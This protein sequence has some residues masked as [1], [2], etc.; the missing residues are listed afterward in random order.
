MTSD[1]SPPAVRGRGHQSVVMAT[2]RASVDLWVAEVFA[3]ELGLVSELL[4]D[5][6]G[7]RSEVRSPVCSS[8]PTP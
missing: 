6:A 4:L 1:L 2:D 5:P 3:G 8:V 7:Q